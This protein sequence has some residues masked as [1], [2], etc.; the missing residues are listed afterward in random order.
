MFENLFC[1]FAAAKSHT[2][3]GS[4]LFLLMLEVFNWHKCDRERLKDS[5]HSSLKYQYFE[6]CIFCSSFREHGIHGSISKVGL[7]SNSYF[8]ICLT[9]PF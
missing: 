8:L 7:L 6:M 5:F 2:C 3:F 9:S 4:I 1:L